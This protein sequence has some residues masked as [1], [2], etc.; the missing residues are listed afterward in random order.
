MKIILLK[1]SH[2]EKNIIHWENSLIIQ[3]SLD[4]NIHPYR[5]PANS[6]SIAQ[7]FT[8][9]VFLLTKQPWATGLKKSHSEWLRLNLIFEN[10]KGKLLFTTVSNNFLKLMIFPI[11]SRTSKITK[12]LWFL[13]TLTQWSSLRDSTFASTR[14]FW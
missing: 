4:K 11:V 12:I 7:A 5:L 1:S 3:M 2:F 6:I 10:L 9:F 8:S 14:D 13:W